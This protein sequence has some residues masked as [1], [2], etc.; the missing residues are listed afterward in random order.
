M[1]ILVEHISP[2][3]IHY[4]FCTNVCTIDKLQFFNRK[5]CKTIAAYAP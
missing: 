2:T 5:G 4:F 1:T 3:K